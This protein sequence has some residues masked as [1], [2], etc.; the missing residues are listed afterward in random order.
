[1]RWFWS[2][3]LRPLRC[4]QF[5][6]WWRKHRAH[7]WF[8]GVPSIVCFRDLWVHCLNCSWALGERI[9]NEK[10]IVP[11]GDTALSLPFV[12]GSLSQQQ[13][14]KVGSPPAFC[15]LIPSSGNISCMGLIMKY[16]HV[17]NLVFYSK[18]AVLVQDLHSSAS[19]SIT[20]FK[21][22]P[23]PHTLP[24]QKATFSLLV[25]NGKIL[26]QVVKRVDLKTSHLSGGLLNPPGWSQNL[27]MAPMSPWPKANH[28]DMYQLWQSDTGKWKPVQN[29]SV[30]NIYPI[31][32]LANTF[33][34]EEK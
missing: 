5:S 27:F 12:W 1:M 17:S 7:R 28:T 3:C 32:Y 30:R 11:I 26:A 14:A 20:L 33:L 22:I 16:C 19:V 6:P 18:Q 13:K 25:R 21:D 34:V 9:S 15:M 23:P 10:T 29:F 2:D 24:R 8:S 4:C 31:R